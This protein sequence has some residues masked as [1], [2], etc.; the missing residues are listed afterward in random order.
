M[1]GFTFYF[2]ICH[3]HCS[4]YA[5]SIEILK[6]CFYR[7]IMFITMFAHKTCSIINAYSCEDM[8]HFGYLFEIFSFPLMFRPVSKRI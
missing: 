5:K 6:L 8:L 3:K 1:R 7:G 4:K 2:V